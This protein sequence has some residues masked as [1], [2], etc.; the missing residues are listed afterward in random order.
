MM[1]NTLAPQPEQKVTTDTILSQLKEWVENKMP[2]APNLWLDACAKL[3]VLKGD[4]SKSLFKLQ[5]AIA[6]VKK[7]LMEKG[8]TAAKAKIWVEST[9]SYIDMKIQEAKIE[10]IEEQI[11][12]S[13]IQARLGQN[14]YHNQ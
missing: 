6:F 4:E 13:K 7:E 1:N 2:I 5:Q 14:D 10:M 11:R 9:D 12:I 3:N 8:Y